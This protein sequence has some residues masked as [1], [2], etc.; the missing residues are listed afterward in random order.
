MEW[1]R[2]LCI[3]LLLYRI[4][5]EKRTCGVDATFEIDVNQCD[6]KETGRNLLRLRTSLSYATPN[7]SRIGCTYARMDRQKLLCIRA[8]GMPFSHTLSRGIPTRFAVCT[9][10]IMQAARYPH[11]EGGLEFP[12]FFAG[13]TNI[14][15]FAAQQRPC[16][17]RCSR[18][19]PCKI[20]P[21]R[22][23]HPCFL[24]II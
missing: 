3:L 4:F 19:Y 15:C 17:Q 10:D 23:R 20:H 8:W 14:N 13:I 11:N 18:A 21:Q 2:N 6:G 12:S 24:T 16:R 5:V 22:R 7:G 9:L 1:L